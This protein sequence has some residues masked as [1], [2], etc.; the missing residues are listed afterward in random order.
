M[1]GRW[2][3]GIRLEQVF[4]LVRELRRNTQAPLLLL[5]YFNIIYQQGIRSFFEQCREAGVDGVI[6]P[7]LPLEEQDA[8][9]AGRTGVAMCC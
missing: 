5:L 2:L 9:A 8:V 1:P 3:R 7:D 6:V 4:G